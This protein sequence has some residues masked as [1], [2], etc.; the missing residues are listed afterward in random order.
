MNNLSGMQ[1]FVKFFVPKSLF[2]SMETESRSWMVRCSNCNHERS[3]WEIGGI[4]WGA[5]G[6]P[7]VKR[8]CANCGQLHWHSIYKK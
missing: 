1:K 3:I 2:A 4:R 6:N 7:R 8:I 5:A